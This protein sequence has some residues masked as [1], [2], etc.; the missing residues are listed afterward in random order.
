MWGSIRECPALETDP[1]PLFH[2]GGLLSVKD[3]PFPLFPSHPWPSGKSSA[4]A[5]EDL[6]SIPVFAADLFSRS[7]HTGDL[8]I[9]TPYCD[10]VR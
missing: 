4:S 6:S 10:L 7:S 8:H 5:A 3:A 1:L 9:G 2:R